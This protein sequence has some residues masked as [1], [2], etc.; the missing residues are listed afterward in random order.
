M[1]EAIGDLETLLGDYGAAVA[2]Y[3][4]AARSR[5]AWARSASWGTSTC[6]SVTWTTARHLDAALAASDDGDRA[7]RARVLADLSLVS[8]R[9]GEEERALELAAE[10]AFAN[11][12]AAGDDAAL[13]QAHN[14]LGILT[15]DSGD[16][17]APASTSSSACV[18]RTSK[19]IPV[20]RSRRF[21]NL[22]L[23]D[24]LEGNV[25]TAIANAE[26]PGAV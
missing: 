17:A 19:Q 3:E 5:R 4:A 23:L 1:H 6:G 15:K 14:I 8:H 10:V 18:G 11:A 12:E 9:S 16:L 7:L 22:A 21:N 25:D 26:R 2:S 20:H 24:Y 13:A